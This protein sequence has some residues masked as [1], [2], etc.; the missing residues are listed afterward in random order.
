MNTLPMTVKT[1]PMPAAR[2]RVHLPI[3]RPTPKPRPRFACIAMP[4][5][6]VSR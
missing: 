2:K 6:P 4:A 3:Y 1:E 5:F